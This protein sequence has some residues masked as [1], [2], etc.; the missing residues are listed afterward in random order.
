MFLFSRFS[1]RATTQTGLLAALCLSVAACSTV[2]T[3][4]GSLI[5]DQTNQVSSQDGAFTQAQKYMRNKPACQT[6]CPRFGM[7]SLV[8]PGRPALTQAAQQ[9]L[10]AQA[11]ADLGLKNIQ[12]LEQLEQAYWNQ[13]GSRD[14][15]LLASRTPYRNAALTVVELSSY[16]YPTSA[17]HGMTQIQYLNWDNREN[18]AIS[19][20]DMLVPGQ[21]NAFDALLR[22]A[23]QVWLQSSE[24]AQQDPNGFV[25]MW[26]FKPS[27]NVGFSD[28]GL[29]V[30]YNSYE[31]APYSAGQPTL[32]IPYQQL[33][34]VLRPA[35]LPAS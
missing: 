25:R 12:S 30:K 18:R 28:Q 11:S 9:A 8:F 23:H 26:P 6:N 33:R 13:A 19:L 17:A 22:Q 2:A 29:L 5:P 15:L 24:D 35:Y 10:I 14:E 31:I 32:L 20:K 3:Q 27:N 34:T 7:D 4:E 1:P 21:Q 16:Y